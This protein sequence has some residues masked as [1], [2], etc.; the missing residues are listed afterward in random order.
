MISKTQKTEGSNRMKKILFLAILI[1]TN[2]A[3]SC[4]N[5]SGVYLCRQNSFRQDTLYTF[6]RVFKYDQWVFTISA[7]PP[8]KDK[9]SAYE[10]VADGLEHEVVDRITGQKLK[11]QAQ[12]T[13]THLKVQGQA[14]L[15][16]GMQVHFSENLSLNQAA[17]LS[18][19]SL[20]IN[21]NWVIEICER[22]MALPSILT[23]L[24]R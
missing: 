14:K 6:D 2:K 23:N 20:D 3:T 4:P 22:H 19:E 16:N 8:G 21:G 12:C 9:V 24:V 17:D 10:V 7:N 1:A 5:L 15:Q 13:S 11:L 18:N